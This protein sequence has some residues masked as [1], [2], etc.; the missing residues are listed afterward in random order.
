MVVTA[1]SAWIAAQAD[2]G[3]CVSVYDAAPADT[4]RAGAVGGRANYIGVDLVEDV[5]QL[6][7]RAEVLLALLSGAIAFDAAEGVAPYL[8]ATTSTSSSNPPRPRS[9]R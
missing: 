9:R 4:D 1:F 3:P 8:T 2:G 6:R 5:A 7:E